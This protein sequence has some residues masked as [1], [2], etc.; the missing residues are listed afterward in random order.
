MWFKKIKFLIKIKISVASAQMCVKKL[1][2]GDIEGAFFE[3]K[4]AF[5]TSGERTN[6]FKELFLK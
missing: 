4:I 5:S 1:N 2:E 3:S 6:F